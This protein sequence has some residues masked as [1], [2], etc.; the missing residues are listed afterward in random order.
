MSCQMGRV[1]HPSPPPHQASRTTV[2]SPKARTAHPLTNPTTL[3]SSLSS[4]VDPG[5]RSGR[6]H[7]Q[8]SSVNTQLAADGGW[9]TDSALGQEPYHQLPGPQDPP[10]SVNPQLAADGG[11]HMDPNFGQEPY[12]QPAGAHDV[13]TSVNTQFW[14]PPRSTSSASITGPAY[15]SAQVHR[16]TANPLSAFAV[17][18]YGFSPCTQPPPPATPDNPVPAARIPAPPQ[19]HQVLP[20]R[21]SRSIRRSNQL[22]HAQL[23]LTARE[24]STV[25]SGSGAGSAAPRR[26]MQLQHGA[27]DR[28]QSLDRRHHRYNRQR[29]LQ[30]VVADSINGMTISAARQLQAERAFFSPSSS[31]SLLAS[32]RT[33]RTPE[34]R[35]ASP[36]LLPEH[37]Y[38]SQQARSTP[39]FTSP[40]SPPLPI[41][42]PRYI[43]RSQQ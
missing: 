43:L 36:H 35:P 14:N 21:A 17:S 42:A 20:I 37:I 41:P 6:A 8:P 39:A 30:R 32:T 9:H 28:I 2:A 25:P 33:P 15:P 26:S 1:P 27:C 10:L 7:D 16:R 22:L 3:T 34:P 18:E 38:R 13:P 4:S 29:R 12:R 5:G 40:P 31:P 24:Q 19:R 11:W 23:R